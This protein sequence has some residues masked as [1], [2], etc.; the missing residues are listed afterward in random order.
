MCILLIYCATNGIQW[1]LEQPESSLMPLH[2]RFVSLGPTYKVKT[3]MGAY[4]GKT[5]KATILRGSHAWMMKLAKKI[6]PEQAAQLDSTGVFRSYE[7]NGKKCVEGGA[8]LKSTQEY[9]PGYGVAVLEHWTQQPT[10]EMDDD[11]EFENEMDALAK[12]GTDHWAD[13]ELDWVATV[14][15]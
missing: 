4:G 8:K 10:T 14:K 13:A 11:I 9:P 2:G 3:Y 15:T 6:S 7:K 5:K 12:L 1:M